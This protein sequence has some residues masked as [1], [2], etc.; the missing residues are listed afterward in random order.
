MSWFVLFYINISILKITREREE[1][2]EK[3]EERREKR[4]EKRDERPGGG[5]SR[6]DERESLESH[7]RLPLRCTF[8]T[9]LHFSSSTFLFL[10]GFSFSSSA[11]KERERERER[12][13][14]GKS[15]VFFSQE[16]DRVTQSSREKLCLQRRSR[17]RSRSFFF[18]FFIFLFI[19]FLGVKTEA[20][21]R[22][23]IIFFVLP[24]C[25]VP[26][27]LSLGHAGARG[28]KRR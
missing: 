25:A 18:F 6:D 2:R 3:R 22:R 26:C 20:A 11:S 13:E 17:S 24:F 28:P 12:D 8:V 14:V 21:L 5:H 7:K 1:R 10:S 19:F 23:D 9:L 15:K 4:E 16:Y 27:G